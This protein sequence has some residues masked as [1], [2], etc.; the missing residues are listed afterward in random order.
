[1]TNIPTPRTRED[2]LITDAAS[3]VFDRF[4]QRRACSFEAGGQLFGKIEDGIWR[5]TDATGLRKGD[6]RSLFGFRPNRKAELA[7][8]DAYYAKG[9]HYLGDWHTHPE[10]LPRPST[11]DT[12]SMQEMV[13][14]SKTELPGFLMVIVGTAGDLH[15]S[16]HKKSGWSKL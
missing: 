11:T 13:A 9:L 6:I 14:V 8:I 15:I 2:L 3:A 4:R 7:E 1:M 10:R 12:D 5:I 16:F